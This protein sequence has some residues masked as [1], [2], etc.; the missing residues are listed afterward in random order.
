MAQVISMTRDLD[1]KDHPSL[2]PF[3]GKNARRAKRQNAKLLTGATRRSKCEKYR[4]LK[5][6]N[7]SVLSYEGDDEAPKENT[8]R[9]G[10]PVRVEMNENTFNHLCHVYTRG[11]RSKDRLKLEVALLV[12]DRECLWSV[13]RD[14]QMLIALMDKPWY[15]RMKTFLGLTKKSNTVPQT[16]GLFDMWKDFKFVVETASEAAS[17]Y[18]EMKGWIKW[19]FS[20][21]H[22]AA[23]KCMHDFL[24]ALKTDSL[25]LKIS[26]GYTVYVDPFWSEMRSKIDVLRFLPELAEHALQSQADV[27]Q[28]K[29]STFLPEEFSGLL[30][31]DM[32]VRASKLF[33]CYMATSLF[34]D[35]GFG[36][37][38]VDSISKMKKNVSDVSFVIQ[39]VDFL[40]R[41]VERVYA[42]AQEGTLEALF[43]KSKLETA[44]MRM[45]EYRSR[46]V[47]STRSR[48]AEKNFESLEEIE[49]YM[50]RLSKEKDP[51]LWKNEKFKHDYKLFMDAFDSYKNCEPVTS[52]S[53]PMGLIMTG[54][55]GVGKSS[56]LKKMEKV[57]RTQWEIPETCEITLRYQERDNFVKE[58]PNARIIYGEDFFTMKEVP[59]Q[60]ILEICQRF[61]EAEGT[62]LEGASIA[63]KERSKYRPNFCYIT[64]NAVRFIMSSA[65]SGYDKLDRRYL[66]CHKVMTEDCKVFCAKNGIME[67]LYLQEF[68]F[69]EKNSGESFRDGSK[70]FLYFLGRMNNAESTGV[71][72]FMPMLGPE[73][74]KDL[75]VFTHEDDLVRYLALLLAKRKSDSEKEVT[76]PT[77]C[78]HGVAVRRD[79]SCGCFDKKFVTANVQTMMAFTSS[80]EEERSVKPDVVSFQDRLQKLQG[81]TETQGNCPCKRSRLKADYAEKF[82][83][84]LYD[85][86]PAMPQIKPKLP[87]SGLFNL[88]AERLAAHAIV[89]GALIGVV[90]LSA[91]LL[92]KVL[93]ALGMLLLAVTA[94]FASQANV[95]P[96]VVGDLGDEKDGKVFKFRQ[97]DL[98]PWVVPSDKQSNVLP[99]SCGLQNCFAICL[100]PR[101]YA[102]PRHAFEGRGDQRIT[103]RGQ[104]V[105][106]NREYIDYDYEE[107]VDL[108]TFVCHITSPPTGC[109]PYLKDEAR[110][111]VH[112]LRWK[113]QD[114]VAAFSQ[115]IQACI[116]EDAYG[117]AGDCGM[118]YYYL[119]GDLASMHVR[120]KPPG[121]EKMSGTISVILDKSVVQRSIARFAK[122]NIVIN[123][124]AN[125]VADEIVKLVNQSEKK[126]APPGDVANI[127]LRMSDADLALSD[128]VFLG[129]VDRPRNKMT[130]ERTSMYEDFKHLLS[131]EMVRPHEGHALRSANWVS[132]Y[133][134]ALKVVRGS[135]NEFVFEAIDEIVAT[136]K[137]LP[138]EK[139]LGPISYKQALVGDDN[140]ALIK[141]TRSDTS[142]GML[143]AL[144]GET[145]ESLFK[146]KGDTTYVASAVRERY[147]HLRD[148]AY[149]G[150]ASILIE[151]AN[152]K[153]EMLKK[154]KVE[155]EGKGRLFFACEKELNLLFK[156]LGANLH[157]VTGAFGLEIGIPFTINPGSKQWDA[158]AKKLLSV[159][160]RM[161]DGDFREYDLSHGCLLDICTE[162]VVKLALALGYDQKDAMALGSLLQSA[163]RKVLV[164]EGFILWR[165]SKL[166]SGQFFTLFLNSIINWVITL[167]W[168]LSTRKKYSVAVEIKKE[169]YSC[170]CGDDFVLVLSNRLSSMACFHPDQLISYAATLGYTI[171][172]ADK[173]SVADW[174]D[175]TSVQFL[176]RA[177]RLDRD[178]TYKGPL[179]R[180]SI[181]RMLCYVVGKPKNVEKRNQDVTRCASREASLHSEEFNEQ[182]LQIMR[183]KGYPFETREHCMKAYEADKLVVWDADINYI[184]IEIAK[185]VS[186]TVTQSSKSVMVLD[187]EEESTPN[188]ELII[189][190]NQER[191]QGADRRDYE[192]PRGR[193]S[194]AFAYGYM[195]AYFK[196]KEAYYKVVDKVELSIDKAVLAVR[197]A[198][199][200]F[201]SRERQERKANSIKWKALYFCQESLYSTRLGKELPTLCT[202]TLVG[203]ALPLCAKICA[204][205]AC[206]NLG[207][208]MFDLFLTPV[209][210]IK[211]RQYKGF[212]FCVVVSDFLLLFSLTGSLH[213]ASAITL[214]TAFAHTWFENLGSDTIEMMLSGAVFANCQLL[215]LILYLTVNG[216]IIISL[217]Y[218]I[219][220]LALYESLD[221]ESQDYISEMLF[222]AINGTI[223]IAGRFNPWTPKALEP[224]ELD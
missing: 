58:V 96:N 54:N 134:T 201:N 219:M 133:T 111:G 56:L 106:I 212:T 66:V 223:K 206:G 215:S 97:A 159:G 101:L 117:E 79:G 120:G 103:L 21:R 193:W 213:L 208:T 109:Y 90:T 203:W 60:S 85:K 210:N 94:V 167:S 35:F 52:P 5:R 152:L 147:V 123:L 222:R 119:D 204:L 199:D 38:F 1:L 113:N 44:L 63:A 8:R 112:R 24:I 148:N 47:S 216:K 49:K 141:A 41:L 62:I 165:N 89:A 187:E 81:D 217:N 125:K 184:D 195:N 127:A 83:E 16:G 23:L 14:R 7:S 209:I 15:G 30:G 114:L 64:T 37:Q 104:N 9:P 191:N 18:K 100:L 129:K 32:I 45:N 20:D 194:V 6:F 72:N 28:T 50:I 99:F 224:P 205:K 140:C 59:G 137:G 181:A 149:A 126:I 142:V 84:Q 128:T 26:L 69:S 121:S 200:E 180:N 218:L 65:S 33:S 202:L 124:P 162:L 55:P 68:F 220:Q 151:R 179:E 95:G 164:L 145:K 48:L 78:E 86:V 138:F 115:S 143:H 71:V 61:V 158:L 73:N 155:R 182:L 82:F 70:D 102:V 110:S 130:G 75:L 150:R 108:V 10:C 173:K 77:V 186:S 157:A 198:P 190:S 2:K 178:G 188:E 43:G 170:R 214:P 116:A 156:A 92:G 107:N 171:T 51:E 161:F 183:D 168:V 160:D 39:G 67:S 172:S 154:S 36:V 40:K 196:V 80:T 135:L 118:P 11:V 192:S 42:F 185:M 91:V 93:A 146:K 189:V 163:M 53:K 122:R 176:K 22:I 4:K 13:K 46:L 19:L 139:D 29:D 12:E 136:Y 87:S 197:R 174:K 131:E 169:Y 88:R 27:P 76:K 74:G 98:P 34:N 57:I 211:C 3:G 175:I 17:D 177:F 153:D 166:S 207:L 25:S 132:P 144:R 221:E 105:F 31:S